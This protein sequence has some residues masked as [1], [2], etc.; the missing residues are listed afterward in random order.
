MGASQALGQVYVEAKQYFRRL[1]LTAFYPKWQPLDPVFGMTTPTERQYYQDCVAD[2]ASLDGAIVDL[3]CWLCSTT[4]PLAMGVLSL[5]NKGHAK[6]EKIYA[7]D[8]FIWETWMDPFMWN[9]WGVYKPGDSFLPEARKRVAPMSSLVELI[10]QDLT[11]YTWKGGPIKILLVDAMKSVE[12]VYAIASSF[13]PN[14]VV[15]SLV[16]HQ[17]FKHYALPWIHLFQYRLRECFAFACDVVPSS[18][19]LSLKTIQPISLERA[20]Q[21]A[22]G[23]LEASESEVQ[24][25]YEYCLGLAKEDVGRA[26]IAAAHVMYYTYRD[27][28]KTAKKIMQSYNSFHFPPQRDFQIAKDRLAAM[29]AESRVEA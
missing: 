12:L 28:L 15:G 20:Q 26:A 4:I 23:L 14:L 5:K 27:D 9:L 6:A 21:A 18:D 3:G 16:I 13:Y 24:A 19:T 25:A 7:F 22:T 2:V 11:Q 1:F 29:E 8:L 10:P 17:D